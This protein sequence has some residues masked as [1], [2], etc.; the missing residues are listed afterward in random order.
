MQSRVSGGLHKSPTGN[1][2]WKKSRKRSKNE[3]HTTKFK[4][5]KENHT[6][7]QKKKKRKAKVHYATLGS[8]LLF[9]WSRSVWFMHF[10]R[11]RER[12]PHLVLSARP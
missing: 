3:R 12:I 1:F 8:G 4:K 2:S 6:K 9:S 10:H 7:N 11:A 5:K